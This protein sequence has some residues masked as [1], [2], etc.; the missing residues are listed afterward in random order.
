MP[1][2]RR[3][4]H[5]YWDRSITRDEIHKDV[6]SLFELLRFE[7]VEIE[8][9]PRELVNLCDFLIDEG[10]WTVV[11]RWE[12]GA[13]PNSDHPKWRTI[14]TR[15][16]LEKVLLLFTETVLNAAAS[17]PNY[18]GRNEEWDDEDFEDPV[19]ERLRLWRQRVVDQCLSIRADESAEPA[20]ESP[21][22]PP[23]LEPQRDPEFGLKPEPAEETSQPAQPVPA[24]AQST[25]GNE[26]GQIEKNIP[27][28]KN[29][30]HHRT[31][32]GWSQDELA[33]RL[34]DEKTSVESW[35][36]K[37]VRY[38]QGEIP[39]PYPSTKKRLADALNVTPSYL[40]S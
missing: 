11:G 27:F 16:A 13:D 32:K 19:Q 18:G 25:P 1:N 29:L 10:K 21:P 28:A 3:Q 40:T 12:E 17:L 34:A 23:E 30:R 35:K 4:L 14:R 20:R 15:K 36:R 33:K 8:H 26:N 22:E 31:H 2:F 7:R 5:Q 37:I 9:L 38:E 39:N 6:I 24:Q